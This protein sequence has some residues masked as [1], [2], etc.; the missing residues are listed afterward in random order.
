MNHLFNSE[1]IHQEL[2]RNQFLK[3]F[4][5]GSTKDLALYL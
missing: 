1:V 4:R 2:S 3:A 5:E